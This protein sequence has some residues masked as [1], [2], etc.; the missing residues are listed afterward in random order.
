MVSSN[1]SVTLAMAVTLCVNAASLAAAWA[2]GTNTAPKRSVSGR[3][4]DRLDFS[5]GRLCCRSEVLLRGR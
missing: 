3:G 5:E 2:R 4:R 1:R